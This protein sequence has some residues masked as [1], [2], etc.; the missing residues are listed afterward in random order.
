MPQLALSMMNYRHETALFC[1]RLTGE[2]SIQ[3]QAVVSME[4]TV[5]GI[6]LYHGGAADHA[7]APQRP[8]D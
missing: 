4:R 7:A 3:I 6:S 2:M 1:S 5:A 8:F